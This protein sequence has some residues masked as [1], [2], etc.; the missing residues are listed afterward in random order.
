MK[1]LD[2]NNVQEAGNFEKLCPGGYICRY[3]DVNDV[4]DKEYLYMEFDI[5]EGR[6][7]DYYKGMSDRFGF[8]SGRCYRSYKEKALPMFKRMIS[9]VQNS[10]PGYAWNY[11]E[12]TLI[13]K[14]VGIVFGEEEYIGNDGTV[15]TR[16]YVSYETS[17]DDI[18]KGKFRT[19]ALKQLKPSERPITAEMQADIA[20][21]FMKIDDTDSDME[22]MPF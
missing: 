8:W 4:S 6:F 12:R 7:K 3:T 9:A 1:R 14:L 21:G 22:E 20:S 5:A 16:L 10:N 2:L 18:K 15:K 17:V 13:G 19:P 11:D